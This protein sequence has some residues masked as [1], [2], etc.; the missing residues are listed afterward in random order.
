MATAV[1]VRDHARTCTK[2]DPSHTSRPS[3]VWA[4]SIWNGLLVSF[5]IVTSERCHAIKGTTTRHRSCQVA[6]HE[7]ARDGNARIPLFRCVLVAGCRQHRC[8]NSAGYLCAHRPWIRLCASGPEDVAGI[9]AFQNNVRLARVRTA[10]VHRA[11]RQQ[12]SA[13]RRAVPH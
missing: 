7:R 3:H 13:Q 2:Y 1:R 5:C 11:A 6:P 10:L 9:F 8:H 12:H 4:K